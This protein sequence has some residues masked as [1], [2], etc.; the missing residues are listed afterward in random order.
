MG[1]LTMAASAEFRFTGRYCLAFGVHRRP[2]CLH[3][4]M[5]TVPDL[6]T[7]RPFNVLR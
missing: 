5:R 6:L 7:L 3:F 4:R 1:Y 2:H